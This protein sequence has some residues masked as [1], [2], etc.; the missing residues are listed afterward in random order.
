MT[1]HCSPTAMASW[2]THARDRR[3][4]MSRIGAGPTGQREKQKRLEPEL[5]SGLSQTL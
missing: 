2:H 1:M 5:L 3:K 4:E